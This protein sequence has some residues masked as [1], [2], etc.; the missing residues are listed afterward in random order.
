MFFP[1]RNEHQRQT[2]TRRWATPSANW[3]IFVSC[4]EGVR[5]AT[6]TLL[7][8]HPGR[9][10]FPCTLDSARKDSKASN[11][12]STKCL[13]PPRGNGCSSNLVHHPSEARGNVDNVRV[14]KWAGLI[15]CALL[16]CYKST[17]LIC[18]KTFPTYH[19]T[20]HHE[21]HDP[22]L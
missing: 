2:A 9:G 14:A 17:L 7:T 22:N 12:Q 20:Q 5:C 16:L 11:D 13:A 4:R 1:V 18:S 10:C 8:A 19:V 21:A 6:S 3:H 15:A